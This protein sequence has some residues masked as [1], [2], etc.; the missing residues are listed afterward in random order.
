MKNLNTL[1]RNSKEISIQKNLFGKEQVNEPIKNF[2]TLSLNVLAIINSFPILRGVLGTGTAIINYSFLSFILIA[3]PLF[4]WSQIQVEHHFKW[5][6]S[7]LLYALEGNNQNIEI[8][9]F[10]GAVYDEK[11]ASLPYFLKRFPLSSNGRLSVQIIE[12]KYEAFEKLPSEDDIVLTNDLQFKVTVEQERK[13]YFG[14]VYFIP[15]RKTAN[16]LERLVHCRLAVRFVATPPSVA[17]RGGNTY[18]SVLNDG[19]I[20]QFAVT[21]TGVHKLT[22]DF[23]SSLGI[24]LGTINPQDIQLYGNGGGMLPE[25]NEV[26]RIDDLEENAI[27][28]VGEEDG[29]FDANDYILFYAE[30]PDKWYFN[31]TNQ[32]FF[33]RKNIYDTKNYY[34]IKIGSE[35]KRISAQNSIN[36]TDYTSESF[37]DYIHLEDDRINV[38][39]A[40]SH[41]QGSGKRWFGDLFKNINEQV[42]D[43]EFKNLIPSEPVF[44]QSQLAGREDNTTYFSIVGAEETLVSNSIGGIDPSRPSESTYANIGTVSGTF[45]ANSDVVNV[46]VKYPTNASG[47]LIQRNAEG[48]LDYIELNA[49]RRLS[50]V[51]NQMAFQDVKSITSAATT[52]RVSNVSANVQ[53]WDISNPLQPKN[54][55]FEQQG[56]QLNFGANGGTLKSFIVF[57]SNNSLISSAEAI[58]KI[59]NQNVHATDEVDMAII[60]HPDFEEQA[61]RLAEHRRNYSNLDVAIVQ[62]TH[63]FNEFSSGKQDPVAIRDFAKMVFDRNPDRFRFLLLF[64]DGSFDYR[65][66]KEGDNSNFITVYETNNSL[67]PIDAYP[68][69]DFYALLNDDEGIGLSG[70]LDLGIGRLP[71]KT[72]ME[73]K[74]VVDKIIRYETDPQ[75]LGDWRNKLVFVADD[76]DSNLHFDDTD[77]IAEKSSDLYKNVNLDKIYLDA[78]PQI[79]TSGGEGYPS[80]TEAINKAMFKGML[81]INYL[82]HGGS[83]G[84]TQERVLDNDRGDIRAWTNFYQLPLFVT[85][86]CSFSGYDDRNQVTAGEQVLLSNKGGGIALYTTTRAVFARSNAAL[87]ES[88]FDTMLYK[89]DGER[90]TLGDIFREGKNGTIAS[91]PNTRKFT[92]LGDP[93]MQLAVPKYNIQ[94]THINKHDVSD[95]LPDTLRALQKVTIKGIVTNDDGKLLTNFNGILFPTLY[96]K[97]ITFSTLGQDPKSNVDNFVLQKNIIF[98]GRASITNGQWKFTF[99][100]PKD[101]NYQ[102]GPGKLSYYAHDDNNN[103]AAGSYEKV[104]IGGTDTNALADDQGPKVE[105]FMNT[106]DFVFGGLTDAN[107]TLLVQLEDDNGINVAGNS[108]GHDLEGVLDNNTQNTYL[109]NDFYEAALDD[110]TKGEVRF[111]LSEIPDGRHGLSVRAWDVANNSA[112][113]YTEFVVASSAEV[114]LEQVLNYPNPFVNATCFQFDHNM[115]NQPLDILIQIFTISGRLVKTIETQVISDGAIRQDDCIQWDGRDDYGDRL[116]KG[117]YLYKV[118]VRTNAGLEDVS[119]KGESDFERLVILR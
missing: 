45:S 115:A 2:K 100:I 114:A 87:V 90:P 95:G 6:E 44:I 22:A 53:I 4:L 42:Y 17:F 119:F 76:E 10:E 12:A 79:S 25:A 62:I 46:R 78:Y 80:V 65:S 50:M 43:F 86:T 118:K 19:D 98:K 8:W 84:W 15:I 34:F 71:V 116:A 29:R 74:D 5:A 104:I 35:G 40:F 93:A 47:N 112:E 102:F 72:A 111:P 97:K 33:M 20:Y 92:L 14:K 85:A 101:I 96:D 1:L 63:I 21:E 11:H 9:S 56:N 16:G 66:I 108:I 75:A 106:V 52:Y 67:S 73:A 23:L 61:Q 105:V 82:G 68:S 7:P 32:R 57:D 60:Y 83:Q 26:E 30:G 31:E 58:G 77:R 3:L 48:W 55:S 94:T 88:V 109:L 64:G 18:T 28:I 117:V 59:D 113:G 39:D 36:N 103:D 91:V 41:T 13:N 110:Y 37:D 38:M 54:Q 70:A 81:A 51:G 27:V 89:R 99:V 24:D 69:D 49:R 107:P